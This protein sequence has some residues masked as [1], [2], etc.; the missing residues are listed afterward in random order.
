[1]AKEVTTSTHLI[2]RKVGVRARSLSS[3]DPKMTRSLR[4]YLREFETGES[5]PDGIRVRIR[6]A[7]GRELVTPVRLTDSGKVSS[8][9]RL[10]PAPGRHVRELAAG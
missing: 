4:Q 8:T 1:M 9:Y 7:D 2:L 3:P 5:N 10:P 6:F